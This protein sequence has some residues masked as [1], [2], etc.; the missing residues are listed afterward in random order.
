M[1]WLLSVLFYT[2]ACIVASSDPI[3]LLITRQNNFF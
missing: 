3:V 1:K 2:L